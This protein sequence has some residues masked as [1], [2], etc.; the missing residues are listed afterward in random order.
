[1]FSGSSPVCSGMSC[2]SSGHRTAHAPEDRGD[3]TSDDFQRLHLKWAG[4][5]AYCTDDFV[6]VRHLCERNVNRRREV[7]Q[8]KNV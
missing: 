3:V 4:S 7:R 6:E 8:R 2:V 1:M 5:I